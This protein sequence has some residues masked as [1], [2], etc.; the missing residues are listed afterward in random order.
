MQSYMADLQNKL[1]DRFLIL[2]SEVKRR[3]ETIEQLQSVIDELKSNSRSKKRL[4][5]TS[6][7]RD[8]KSAATSETSRELFFMVSTNFPK[9]ETCKSRTKKSAMEVGK[10]LTYMLVCWLSFLQR[11]DS[12]D[13]VYS[14]SPKSTDKRSMKIRSRKRVAERHESF[15]D[16][17]EDSSDQ[18][19][20]RKP[21]LLGGYQ[22]LNFGE[23]SDSVVVDI[24][25]T[26]SSSTSSSRSCIDEASEEDHGDNQ[27][28]CDDW[29]I[30][31]LAA[32]LDRRE[33]TRDPAGCFSDSEDHDTLL[34]R[35]RKH[36]V[37]E[38]R[39]TIDDFTS[40]PRAASLDQF[41]LKYSK[42]VCRTMS[43]DRDR[44]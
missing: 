37:L 27:L 10:N 19:N 29:E 15:N 35:R 5:S 40:R 1:Q 20:E 16:S 36:S 26:L 4:T 18:E 30:R 41:N 23:I 34:R 12:G 32:E 11:G 39:E 7:R 8:G 6:K 14:A 44:L 28:H 38:R 21:N 13:T 17:H 2:E 9:L 43:F 24:D 22:K 33:S 42:S 31:M 25:N 3:G